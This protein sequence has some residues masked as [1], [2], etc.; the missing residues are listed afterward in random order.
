MDMGHTLLKKISIVLDIFLTAVSF[1]IAYILR[2][3]FLFEPWGDLFGLD[4]YL[5]VFWIIIPVWPIVLKQMGLYNGAMQARF[6]VL[7]FSILKA[8]VIASLIL[9]SAIYA[10]K[11]DL[12]SRLFFFMFLS[13]NFLLLTLGRI[14][15]RTLYRNPKSRYNDRRVVLVSSPSGAAQFAKLIQQEEEIK[16][17]IL[18][19]FTAGC[20]EPVKDSGNIPCLGVLEDVQQYIL[21]KPVDE[22]IFFLSKEHMVQ[23]ESIIMDC[24]KLGITVRMLLDIYDLKLA[25]TQISY[26]G[27]IPLLTFHTVNLNE[28][29]R[30]IKRAMDIAGSLIGLVLTAV[31]YILLAP[32]IKLESPGPVLYRQIRVGQNGRRFICYKFRTMFADAEKQ[33]AGL[34]HLNQM[35]GALFKVNGD[36]RITKVGAVLRKLSLDEFPQFYNVLK[37]EMS[38]V[39]T[40]PPTE[41]EVVQYESHHRRRLS[42]KPGITGLWQVSGRNEIQD[43]DQVVALD[44][45]YIDHWSLWMDIKIIMKTFGAVFNRT[46]Q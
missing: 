29:Q 9:A 1:F 25:K 34:Q 31:L 30:M 24:E 6:S 37:G 32:L 36:P 16:I 7:L 15:L 12:F 18:G 13:L 21:S 22:V 14:L 33:R 20:S 28:N 23:I 41:D 39:G 17:A 10:A 4:R 19:F 42:I 40:R 26:L 11:D 38:L 3:S 46:G 45:T 35:K 8:V 44:V 27:Q 5:W 2:G 43:F